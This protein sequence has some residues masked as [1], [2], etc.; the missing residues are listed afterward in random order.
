MYSS[1]ICHEVKPYCV[2][3][4]GN[5]VGH[6][7]TKRFG[8]GKVINVLGHSNYTGE[9]VKAVGFEAFRKDVRSNKDA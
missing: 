5:L 2:C 4:F 6:G 8:R 7:S 1:Y 9:F 3:N